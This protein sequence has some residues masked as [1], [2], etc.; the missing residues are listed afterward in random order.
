MP[1][2]IYSNI[3]YQIVSTATVNE[4]VSTSTFTYVYSTAGTY[5]FVANPAT[6]SIKM[7]GGGGGGAAGGGSPSISALTGGGAGA[8]TSDFTLETGEIWTLHVGQ[9][10][11]S[12]TGTGQTG[13]AVA[14]VGGTGYGQGGNAAGGTNAWGGGGGG[15]SSAIVTNFFGPFIA[16]GGGGSGSYGSPSLAGAGGTGTSAGGTLGLSAS[17]GFSGLNEGGGGGGSSITTLLPA[18]GGGRGGFNRGSPMLSFTGS[19]GTVGASLVY[20]GNFSDTDWSTGV[21]VG[22]RGGIDNGGDGKIVIRQTVVRGTYTFNISAPGVP[23]GT[24]LYWTNA[25]TTTADDFAERTTSG[26]FTVTNNAGSVTLNIVGDAL[27]EGS[28]TIV[29]QL[30]ETSTTGPIVAV[31]TVTINDAVLID[32]VLNTVNSL[33]VSIVPGSTLITEEGRIDFYVNTQNIADGTTLYWTISG[34][35]GALDF[36]QQ[37]VNGSFVVTN[38]QGIVKLNL[39]PDRFT[40]GEEYVIF[41]VR[42]NS[43]T[44]PVLA[45]TG[46]ITIQ[47]TSK[48]PVGEAPLY[49]FS[50]LTF[51]NA[52]LTGASG[53]T[54]GQLLAQYNTTLDPWLN[55]T[56]YYDVSPQGI[57]RWTVPATATYRVTAAGAPGGPVGVNRGAVI[58]G[59]FGLIKGDIYRILVGQ[60]GGGGNSGGGASFVV[61]DGGNTDADILVIA[62][63]G[64]GKG[65]GAGGQAGPANSGGRNGGG[66]GGF[67]ANCSWNGSAGGGFITDGGLGSGSQTTGGR[68]F[69][70]VNGGSGGSGGIGPGGFGGGGSGGADSI[71]GAGCGGGYTGGDGGC[72]GSSGQ[73]GGSYNNGSNQINTANVNSLSSGGYVIISKIT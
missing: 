3:N 61:K 69:A 13:D 46:R 58:Q 16:A 2:R 45:Q 70:F 1:L 8:I 51:T 30:R 37:V 57:Q 31:R 72:D 52:G 41:A 7:W 56:S 6:Y 26:L 19:S 12:A 63:G 42:L 43:V 29:F 18:G 44:G 48:Q 36:F 28:E 71:A 22:G 49:T 35:G 65:G 53:P 60:Y 62:G 66:G 11:R 59:D 33:G 24:V 32:P 17:A 55:N 68:G 54:K 34:T 67:G 10:G 21:G 47:D 25:G 9:G 27:V 39:F 20:P 64:G 15:G 23:D 38:G 4:G 50:F 14:G 40:E 5:S 73:G